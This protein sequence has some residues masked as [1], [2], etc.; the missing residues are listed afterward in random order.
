MEEVQ[1]DVNVEQPQVAEPSAPQ[2]EVNT[3]EQVEPTPP[4]PQLGNTDVDE[5][6]V[7]WKNRAMEYQRKLE[8][9]LE[10]LESIPQQ[11]QAQPEY[12]VA[13]LLAFAANPETTPNDR[14]W[15][16]DM[17]EKKEKTESAKL[18]RQELESYKNEQ[19]LQTVKQQ[20]F[21]S[22]LQRNPD[23]IV[24]DANGNFAG[25]N[26][27]SDKLQL[28]NKYMSDP[29]IVNHPRGLEV[30]EAF[31]IRDLSR[32]TTQTTQQ[33]KAEIGDLKKKTLVEGGG[34]KAETVSPYLQALEKSKSGNLKDAMDAWRSVKART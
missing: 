34:Q 25:W 4:M 33:M 32:K 7:P 18:V 31:A 10:R 5:M 22:V 21:Q 11:Q 2:T 20:V 12:S 13:Q 15:A 29:E 1:Q 17:V 8:K 23:I 28:I 27:K 30:A 16:L 24:K 19:K 6:G 9:T 14:Q 26:M 3:P